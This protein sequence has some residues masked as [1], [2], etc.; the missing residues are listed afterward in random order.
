MGS[1]WNWSWLVAAAAVSMDGL[2][3]GVQALLVLVAEDILTWDVVRGS[4]F[5]V[6]NSNV[7][8]DCPGGG[9]SCYLADETFRAPRAVC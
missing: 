1:A 9:R 7:A 4:A 8:Y 5:I 3:R 6:S 2:L